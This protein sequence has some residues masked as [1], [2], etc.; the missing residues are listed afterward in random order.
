[1]NQKG[2]MFEDIVKYGS[3]S[4]S[5]WR[6]GT[7]SGWDTDTNLEPFQFDQCQPSK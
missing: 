5:T 2:P 1:M 3:K 7:T 4:A 6:K